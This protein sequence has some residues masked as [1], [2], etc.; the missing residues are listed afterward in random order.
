MHSTA[1]DE[2]PAEVLIE[3][4]R[5]AQRQMA[6]LAIAQLAAFGTLLASIYIFLLAEIKNSLFGLGIL[7]A[8]LA[9][10]LN[11]LVLFGIIKFCLFNSSMRKHAKKTWTKP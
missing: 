9:A 7:S 2:T 8:I 3:F 4:T 11:L 1:V 5:D 10:L 6:A